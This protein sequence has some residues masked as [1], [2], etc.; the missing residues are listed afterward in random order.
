MLN[1]DLIVYHFKSKEYDVLREKFKSI[2]RE[3]EKEEM[4]GE[5]TL[6]FQEVLIDWKKLADKIYECEVIL[7]NI[8]DKILKKVS[9]V[10]PYDIERM[11]LSYLN[12]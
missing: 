6:Y 1:K 9:I 12:K 5:V 3:L 8:E 2:K 11:I 10:L 4:I 7:T